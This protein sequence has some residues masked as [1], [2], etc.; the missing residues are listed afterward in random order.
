MN[1]TQWQR[2]KP[3]FQ[4]ALERPA[5]AR[6]A[7]LVEACAGDEEL[8]QEVEALL[9]AHE[10]TSEFIAKPAVAEALPNLSQDTT[11]LPAGQKLGGY[12]IQRKIGAGGMGE[13]YL[14]RDSRW[15]RPVALKVLPV[16]L[17]RDTDR[18]RRFQQEARAASALNHPN[19]LTIYEVGSENGVDFIATEYIAGKTLRDLLKTGSLTLGAVLDIIIQA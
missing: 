10:D 9:A 2:V 12:E 8:L 7:Y 3:I 11:E 17:T 14:A 18:V 6:A 16:S 5:S 13:V 19:I 1:P 4:A 15:G